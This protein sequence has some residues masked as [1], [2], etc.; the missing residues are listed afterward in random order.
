MKRLLIALIAVGLAAGVCLAQPEYSE[1]EMQAFYQRVQ[2][3]DFRSGVQGFEFQDAGFNGAGFGF[4]YN[5]K[6]YVG[7]FQQTS[8]LGGVEQSGVKLRMI[9][10]TQGIKLTKR[11]LAN[12][13]LNLYTKAGIGYV[14]HIFSVAGQETGDSNMSFSYGGGAEIKMKEGIWLLLDGSRM[15]M[16][17]PQLTSYEPDRDKWDSSWVFTTGISFQF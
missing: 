5:F 2:G 6:H 13:K 9:N 10:A 12:E 14:Y 7:L 17:L 15:A 4:V 1:M 8:F 3:F 11:G 16:G